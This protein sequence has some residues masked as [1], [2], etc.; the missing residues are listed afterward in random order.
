MSGKKANKAYHTTQHQE[1]IPVNK[2]DYISPVY[3]VLSLC[4]KER[5]RERKRRRQ[6][7]MQ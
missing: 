2:L 3:N 6:I 4:V 7:G 1:M 5:E